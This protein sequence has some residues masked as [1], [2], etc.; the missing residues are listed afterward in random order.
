MHTPTCF[1]CGSSD[2]HGEGYLLSRT[3]RMIA[4]CD[5]CRDRHV[6]IGLPIGLEYLVQDRVAHGLP[7]QGVSYAA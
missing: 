5:D 6:R 3:M 2:L 7:E 1:T 4:I